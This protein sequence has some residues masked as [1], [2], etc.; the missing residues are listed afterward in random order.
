MTVPGPKAA[1]PVPDVLS[2]VATGAD[3]PAAILQAHCR[4]IDVRQH[5]HGRMVKIAPSAS[6]QSVVRCRAV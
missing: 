1:P 6:T 2:A 3:G 5:A 4:P